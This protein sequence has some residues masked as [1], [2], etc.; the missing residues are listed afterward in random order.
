MSVEEQLISTNT[1]ICSLPHDQPSA[2]LSIKITDLIQNASTTEA[3]EEQSKASPTT[4]YSHQLSSLYPLL[5]HNLSQQLV[6]F[7]SNTSSS[8][9]KSV[10]E[11]AN[12]G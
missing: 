1:P 7:L 2:Q 8:V 11:P 4:S 3:P 6:A 5:T 9:L 12:S 10:I